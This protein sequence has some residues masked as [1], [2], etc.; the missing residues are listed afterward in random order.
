MCQN[1]GVQMKIEIDTSKDSHEEI[2]KVV[3]LLSHLIGDH[4][5]F[6]AGIRAKHEREHAEEK[7]AETEAGM[8]MFDFSDDEGSDEES[9]SNSTSSS[10]TDEMYASENYGEKKKKNTDFDFRDVLSY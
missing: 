8:S 5:V 3:E 4:A 6:D 7:K 10:H 2:R 9:S 1:R